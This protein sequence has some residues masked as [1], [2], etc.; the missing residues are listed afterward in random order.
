MRRASKLLFLVG[1][2]LVVSVLWPYDPTTDTA[3]AVRMSPRTPL[4]FPQ[5]DPPSFL[6]MEDQWNGATSKFIFTHNNVSVLPGF[7]YTLDVP[8]GRTILPGTEFLLFTH[9]IRNADGTASDVLLSLRG[10]NGAGW[11]VPLTA[12]STTIRID[13]EMNDWAPDPAT[14]WTFW[15]S[16]DKIAVVVDSL[17][18][19]LIKMDGPMPDLID[20]DDRWE[21]GRVVRIFDQRGDLYDARVGPGEPRSETYGTGQAAPALVGSTPPD[22]PGLKQ[23]PAR[24]VAE[25]HVELLYNS[26]TSRELHYRP[27]LFFRGANLDSPEWQVSAMPPTVSDPDLQ[28]GRFAWRLPIDPE[29]WDS[30]FAPQ[31]GWEIAVNW[32]GETTDRPVYMDGDYHFWME[33]HKAPGV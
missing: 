5:F 4:V 30:P 10:A 16:T 21:E 19:D 1:I 31:T 12:A 15:L 7:P 17:R 3:D 29:M 13:E 20:Y 22:Q 25:L 9:D 14:R 27:T 2:F 18:L 6:V 28:E 33:V 26:S 11:S 32:R 24:D 8:V 23:V